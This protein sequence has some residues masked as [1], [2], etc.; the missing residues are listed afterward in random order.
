MSQI[1]F[2]SIA[3]IAA[4][5]GI[6]AQ[7]EP[8]RH[9]PAAQQ[10]GPSAKQC[11]QA[12]KWLVESEGRAGDTA[13]NQ[14]Q[15]AIWSSPACVAYRRPHQFDV[16]PQMRKTIAMLKENG[17]D[18]EARMPA[19]AAECQAKA[20]GALLAL[21]ASERS[22]MTVEEV[23]ATCVLNA[24]TD[25]YAEALN[26][27]NARRQTQFDKKK[28]EYERLKREREQVLAENTRIKQANADKLAAYEAEKARKM[29]EWRTAVALC[30]KGKREYCAK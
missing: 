7:S 30:K 16:T 20:P 21:P 25:L 28:A 1:F 6:T 3:I 12:K 2:A 9:Q 13:E 14:K 18:I 17:I 11:E 26:E 4:A 27:L 22:T 10:D 19:K 15:Y 24:R 5:A 23:A 29:E 8:M